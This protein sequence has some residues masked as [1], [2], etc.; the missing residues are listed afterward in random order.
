[1]KRWAGGEVRQDGGGRADSTEEEGESR[2][3]S[4]DWRRMMSSTA[5]CHPWTA[6]GDCKE[7]GVHQIIESRFPQLHHRMI[8]QFPTWCNTPGAFI[9]GTDV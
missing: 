9:Q 2:R 3:H 5:H 8:H 4:T 1:M 6:P 7:E